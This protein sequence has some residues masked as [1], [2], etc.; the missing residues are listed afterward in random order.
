LQDPNNARFTKEARANDLACP[1]KEAKALDVKGINSKNTIIVHI[2]K[3]SNP[4]KGSKSC[5][6]L[7]S[8]TNFTS[9]INLTTLRKKDKIKAKKADRA[10]SRD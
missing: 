5:I 4:V 3:G 9:R 7:T 2:P 1:I 8:R 10:K 6:D